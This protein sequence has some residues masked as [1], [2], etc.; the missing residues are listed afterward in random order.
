VAF[1]QGAARGGKTSDGT[2]CGTDHEREGERLPQDGLEV[3]DPELREAQRH[4]DRDHEHRECEPETGH[5]AGENG[6]SG[7][8][9]E[10]S[11]LVASGAER[12]H[13]DRDGQ[14]SD[15]DLERGIAVRIGRE[16]GRVDAE[17]RH[18][19]HPHARERLGDPDLEP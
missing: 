4:R 6:F 19:R 14:R 3:I 1:V 5:G 15:R 18:E 12:E 2:A 16:Q 11:R 17:R 10:S 7:A 8:R 9:L 13:Q